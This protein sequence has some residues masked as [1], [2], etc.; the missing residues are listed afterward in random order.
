MVG[1]RGIGLCPFARLVLRFECFLVTVFKVR[2]SFIKVDDFLPIL[3]LF[4]SFPLAF[5]AR[6]RVRCFSTFCLHLF[7]FWGQLADLQINTREGFTLSGS[8][9][10]SA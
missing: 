3:L 4:S 7:T 9:A 8:A 1:G 10:K 5:L 2:H 6:V